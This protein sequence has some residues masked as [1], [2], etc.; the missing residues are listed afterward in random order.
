VVKEHKSIIYECTQQG[1][2]TLA[3][4]KMKNITTILLFSILFEIC[5]GQTIDTTSATHKKTTQQFFPKNS[6]YVEILGNAMLYSVNYERMFFP[7]KR[8]C[9]SL[10]TGV[11]YIPGKV[12]GDFMIPFLTNGILRLTKNTFIELGFGMM[13]WTYNTVN[14]DVS[15]YSPDYVAKGTEIE[16]TSV[17]GFRYK[18]KKGFLLRID[19]TPILMTYHKDYVPWGGISLGYCF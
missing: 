4:I 14:Q 18:S 2:S 12:M 7:K 1:F 13:I 6:F 19:Y 5:V 3:F 15:P 10:R 16:L 17:A 9:L 8:I 11:G